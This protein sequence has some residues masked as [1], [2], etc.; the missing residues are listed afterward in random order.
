MLTSYQ[1]D[2]IEQTSMKFE[3]NNIFHSI[4][5]YWK[6]CLQNRG[7]SI[8]P[9]ST[10]SSQTLSTKSSFLKVLSGCHPHFSL[11]DGA[12]TLQYPQRVDFGFIRQAWVTLAHLRCWCDFCT[13]I[14]LHTGL[15]FV[16]Q[17]HFLWVRSEIELLSCVTGALNAGD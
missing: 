10:Q 8:R 14:S 11:T 5:C 7:L 1:L 3:L 6:C 9:Q 17:E 12:E 16:H 15:W 2:L 13:A 4:K